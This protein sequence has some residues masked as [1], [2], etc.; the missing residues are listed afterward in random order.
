MAHL[1]GYAQAFNHTHDAT[2][3]ARRTRPLPSCRFHRVLSSSVGTKLLIGATGLAL[4]AYMVL[5]LAG[6]ALIFFGR[7]ISTNTRTSWISNPLI[8]PI[9]IGLLLVFLAHIYKAVTMWMRNKAA[10]PVATGRRSSPAT[11]AA[12]ASLRRP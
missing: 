5:H 1:R 10:R 8:V 4:L 3:T 9:E 7:D 2:F 12:R 11:P 6:N